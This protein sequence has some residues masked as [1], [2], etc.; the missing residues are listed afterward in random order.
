[1]EKLLIKL[2]RSNAKPP[3]RQTGGSVGFDVAACIEDDVLIAPG[4]TK[5]LGSGFAI[6]LEPGYAAFIYARSG[7]GIKQ[8]IVPANCVGVID[9]DY[10]GEVTVGLRNNSS[11]PFFVRDGDRIAQMVI[12]RCALPE[13]VFCEQLDETSRNDG[14]F[15]STGSS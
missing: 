11:V 7:L 13:L 1:M 10:R 6:A 4:E 15:G 8:G 9:S 5:M 14:G 2:L 12:C 3:S